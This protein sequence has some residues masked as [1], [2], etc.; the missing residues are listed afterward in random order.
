M[1]QQKQ[2]PKRTHTDDARRRDLAKI[3]IAKKQLCMPDVVYREMLG[4][5]AGV[6]S[7]ADLDEHGRLKVLAHLKNCG[8]RPAYK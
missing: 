1:K 8:F 6:A 4:N 7:A 5:I 2:I 3:H